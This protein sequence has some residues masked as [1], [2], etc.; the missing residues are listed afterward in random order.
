MLKQILETMYVD[1]ELLEVMSDDQKELL[2][3]QMREEQLR[4]WKKRDAELQRRPQPKRTPRKVREGGEE[5]GRRAGGQA[6]RRVG[7]EAKREGRWER[8]EETV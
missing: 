2:F 4:R 8:D 7:R 3:R 6:G 1:P 5:A